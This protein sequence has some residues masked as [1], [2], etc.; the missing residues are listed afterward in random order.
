[1]LCD[2]IWTRQKCSKETPPVDVL[3]AAE[4]ELRIALLPPISRGAHLAGPRLH[5]E[6]L[7]ELWKADGEVVLAE[8]FRLL[9]VETVADVILRTVAA[10]EYEGDPR[11]WI[12]PPF[13]D[14]L[15]PLRE[16]AWQEVLAGRLVLEA[17][18]GVTGRRHHPLALALLPRL[19]PDWELLRL[20]RDGRDEWIEVRARSLAATAV[21][22][23][24]WQGKPARNEL[25]DAVEDAAEAYSS[26]D[27]P[28]F[29]EF[30]AALKIRVPGVTQAQVRNALKSRSLTCAESAVKPAKSNRQAEIVSFFRLTI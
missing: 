14:L 1:V 5:A 7:V 27:P 21:L 15:P 2:K 10:N 30:W 8:A 20:M 3:G 25:K 6:R 11:H 23:K 28:S 4:I 18:K 17:I 26:E 24:P 12:F 9:D 13:A 29:D 16:A 22:P 19:T